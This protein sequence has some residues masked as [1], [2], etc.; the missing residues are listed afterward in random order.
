MFSRRRLVLPLA[1][2]LAGCGAF[3]RVAPQRRDTPPSP[4]ALN[5]VISVK[6][7]GGSPPAPVGVP[8]SITRLTL[9]HQGVIW[10]PGSDVAGYLLRLQNWSRN[11]RGWVD[12]PYHYVVAPDGRV[13]AAR[14]WSIAG[15]TNTEYDPRG[16]LL[17]MLLGD[18]EVQLPTPEQWDATVDLLAQLL[19]RHGL[20]PDQIDSHRDHS[21]QTLCPGAHLYARLV[22]LRS[23]V[24]TRLR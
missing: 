18:F 19:P 13:Y 23:A 24:A 17:V 14:P 6:A 2:S 8:Q 10:Q 21:A 12:I 15:D 9:H 1:L 11:T 5:R 16:H 20:G 4:S 7:W 3:S 22:E